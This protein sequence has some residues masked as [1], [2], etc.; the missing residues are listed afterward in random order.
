MSMHRLLM[1]RVKHVATFSS[2]ISVSKIKTTKTQLVA[3]EN[4]KGIEY[5]YSIIL[6][7]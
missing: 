5:F 3:V 7:P 2:H 1:N 6:L 4:K